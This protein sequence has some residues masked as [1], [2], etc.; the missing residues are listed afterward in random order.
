MPAQAATP[1]D[2]NDELLRQQQRDKAQQER[3]ESAPDVR[4]DRPPEQGPAPRLPERESP[5]FVIDRLVL[6]GDAAERFAWAL[7]HAAGEGD[8]PIGRCLGADGV[9]LVMKRVQNAI[10][11]DGYVTA[12]IL[13]EPQDLKSGTL[14]LTVVPGRVRAIRSPAGTDERI[15]YWNAFPMAPGDLLNLRDIEQALENLK[16]VPTVE[17][18]ILIA[19]SEA[20]DAK[21][22]D[23]D[24]VVSW[25]QAFPYRISLSI[26][27]SGSKAT[28]R[29][30]AG[31]TISADHLF[32]LNDLFYYT[33]NQNLG[34]D[35]DAYGTRGDTAHYSLPVGYWLLG[36]THGTSDYHQ[37]VPGIDQTHR[38]SGNSRSSDIRL[39]RMV[40]RDA[41]S[42]T[43]LGLRG[44]QRS[45]HNF[46]DDTEVLAQQRRTAGWELNGN[47]KHFLG[48]ATLEVNLAWRQGTGAHRSQPAPEQAIGEGASHP[49]LIAAD[50]T[51]AKP[52][53]WLGLGMRYNLAWRA[54]WNRTPLAPPDRFAI[55]GRYTVR[56]FDGENLL[57]ADHGWLVRNDLSVALGGGAESYFGLDHG[58]VGG[59]AAVRLIGREL[60]GAALGLRGSLYSLNYDFFVGRPL[61]KP[62]GFVTARSTSGFMLNLSY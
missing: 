38:Y 50:A 36:V 17:A 19:P 60:E 18:D 55:G 58:R 45:S 11:G 40:R 24:L 39:S 33:A 51:L 15:T 57:S 62:A 16:R 53:T 20:P 10:V 47:H 52:F 49:R 46:I 25:R 54:Q 3:L 29:Y 27:D 22:G 32:T 41:A 31:L 12:R 30:Q 1:V 37:S 5:C 23:S 13:A 8:S 2:P 9:N 14:Q 28:G 48:T 43:A 61:K 35:D 56:G 44:W 59:P 6:K 42:K 34:R 21:P 4:L 26:D 7:D